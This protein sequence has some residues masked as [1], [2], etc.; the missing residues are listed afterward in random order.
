ME[1]HRKTTEAKPKREARK[2]QREENYNIPYK[3][4]HNKKLTADF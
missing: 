4:N 2:Q 3:R 1:G